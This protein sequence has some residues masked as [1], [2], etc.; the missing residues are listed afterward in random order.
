MAGKQT[1]GVSRR[2]FGK[3]LGG[4]ALLPMATRLKPGGPTA[5]GATSLPA[6]SEVEGK[7]GGAAAARVAGDQFAGPQ[8]QPA[9]PGADEKYW[10]SV[11]ALFLMPADLALMNAANLCPTSRPVL[12]VLEAETRWVDRNPS[13][14]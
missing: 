3:L 13:M 12:E 9:P 1:D 11:R 2:E 5:E 10:R 6:L 8:I 4:A 14:P 7:A